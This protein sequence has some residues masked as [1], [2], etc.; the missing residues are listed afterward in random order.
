[1][2]E[3]EEILVEDAP[4]SATWIKY[5]VI[6]KQV[7]SLSMR[8]KRSAFYAMRNSPGCTSDTL[9]PK[10]GMTMGEFCV[11]HTLTQSMSRKN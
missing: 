3:A 5:I 9:L 4:L 8:E 2:D 10:L 7:Q 1:M 6:M 11:F